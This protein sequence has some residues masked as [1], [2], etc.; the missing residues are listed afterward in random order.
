MINGK[1]RD[2]VQIFVT[3]WGERCRGQL[4]RETKNCIG[5]TATLLWRMEALE[6]KHVR[7]FAA[8]KWHRLG[9]LLTDCV[10]AVERN[11]QD[12]LRFAQITIR[13]VFGDC[14]HAWKNFKEVEK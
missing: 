3:K 5:Q 4:S 9:N 11:Q 14:S 8:A 6:S 7:G 2:R 12:K 1:H 10:R 13:K